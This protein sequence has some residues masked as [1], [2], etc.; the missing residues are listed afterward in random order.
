[1]KK[2]SVIGAC[3]LAATVVLSVPLGVHTSL[4][5]EHIVSTMGIGMLTGCAIQSFKQRIFQVL[6]SDSRQGFIIYFRLFRILQDD[7][8]K[9]FMIAYQDKFA[10]TL[11]PVF[12]FG[13]KYTQQLRFQYLS[14]LIYNSHIEMLQSEKFRFAGDRCYC[15]D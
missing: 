11:F 13:T 9:L 10:N 3:V 6:Q 5:A 2:S 14:S 15:T 8:R 7:S 4:T 1:M 12:P